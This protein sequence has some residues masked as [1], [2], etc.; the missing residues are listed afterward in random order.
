MEK[1]EPHVLLPWRATSAILPMPSHSD[2][3]QAHSDSDA[4]NAVSVHDNHASHDESLCEDPALETQQLAVVSRPP[5]LKLPAELLGEI[6]FHCLLTTADGCKDNYVTPNQ[7]TA[8]L[9]LCWV[10]MHWRQVALSTP[11]LWS[12][13]SAFRV[14]G[15]PGIGSY[16]MQFWLDHSQQH[17]LSFHLSFQPRDPRC[18]YELLRLFIPHIDRCCDI[19]IDLDDTIACQLLSLSTTETASLRS[20]S[21]NTHYCTKDVIERIPSLISSFTNIRRLSWGTRYN[22]IPTL[23]A[24]I[25]WSQLD[26]VELWFPLR[27][28]DLLAILAQCSKVVEFMSTQV[29]PSILHMPTPTVLYPRLRSLYIRC[30]CSIEPSPQC[31]IKELMQHFTLPALR[32]LTVIHVADDSMSL[33]P[34]MFGDF[35]ARSACRLESFTFYQNNVIEEDL[36]ACLRLPYLQHLKEIAITDDHM[37]D[38]TLRALTYPSDGMDDAGI[39]PRLERMS[40]FHCYPSNGLAADMIASRW[41]QTQDRTQPASLKF[42]EVHFHTPHGAQPRNHDLDVSRFDEFCAGGLKIICREV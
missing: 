30:Y 14:A 8:P 21:L 39:L 31:C 6:F 18:S 10:C 33:T 24:N 11:V 16:G 12:S 36:I 34:E 13:F 35:L 25:P 26:F 32:R 3:S 40:L 1:F 42:V 29:N 5:I 17:P 28:D 22:K 4:L 19:S 20:V 9:L 23:L 15:V 2:P 7:N 41:A 37:A 38:R 27:A